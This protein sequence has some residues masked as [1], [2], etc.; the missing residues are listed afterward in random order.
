MD[1]LRIGETKPQHYLFRNSNQGILVLASLTIEHY[2]RAS[3]EV[4][5]EGPVLVLN[6]N[7]EPL[8]ICDT[9]RAITLIIGG[10]ARMLAN[11][12]G[13]I[14]SVHQAFPL[15]SVI[16]L[17]HMIHRP[18]PLPRLT[19]KEVFRRDSFTCQYCGRQ[20]PHLTIDHIVPRHRGGAHTWR[21]LVAACPPCNRRKGGRTLDE[22]HM[23]LLHAPGEPPRDARYIFGQYREANL[24]WDPFLEGW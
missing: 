16:Q 23:R 2:T 20:T 19:K 5:M 9:R 15:P 4:S 24:E 11:G 12:R 6:A 8:H 22:I 10:K 7:F 14:H 17:S 21:N 3:F 1:K 13:S 18:R